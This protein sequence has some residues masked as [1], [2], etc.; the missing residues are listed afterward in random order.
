MDTTESESQSGYLADVRAK[1]LKEGWNEAEIENVVQSLRR[2]KQRVAKGEPGWEHTAHSVPAELRQAI[3]HTA[4]VA[5]VSCPGGP[6]FEL[7]AAI[8]SSFALGLLA[9]MMLGEKGVVPNPT[10][11]EVYK[12]SL[13]WL[14][15]WIDEL[16]P[17]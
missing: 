17:R 16:D 11:R 7:D 3:Q 14:S 4:R 1:L 6:S 8:D 5:L 9:G 13:P 10:E 12:K 15:R 2:S